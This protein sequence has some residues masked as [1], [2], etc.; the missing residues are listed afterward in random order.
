M[1]ALLL[2]AS[3]VSGETLLGKL[4]TLQHDVKGDVYAKDQ[5]TLVIKNFNYDG[6]GPDAFFWVGKTGTPQ[7]NDN[8]MTIILGEQGKT[9]Q[10]LDQT[11]PVLRKYTNEEVELQLPQGFELKNLKWLSIWCRKFSI[12]F[13]NLMIPQDIE[14]ADKPKEVPHPLAPASSSPEPEPETEPESEPETEPEP[15]YK[16]EPEPESEPKGEPEPAGAA[17]LHVTVA[18]IFVSLLAA[19]GL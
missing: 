4:S 11:A 16:P 13:G 12:D 17:G 7:S 15:E 14:V 3:A 1:L 10:Y 8:A 2:L 9:Y 18:A 6:A 19:R 5:S